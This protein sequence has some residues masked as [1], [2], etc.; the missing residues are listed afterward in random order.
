[1][2][3]RRPILR[4]AAVGVLALPILP[5]IAQEE[6]GLRMRFGLEQRLEYA[7]NLA[8][9]LPAEGATAV[10]STRLSFNLSSETRTER[11]ALNVGAALKL[12]DGPDGRDAGLGDP[13]LE[14]SYAREAANATFGFDA[15]YRSSEVDFL[16]PLED[17]INDDGVIELPEDIDDLTGTGDRADY[18]INTAIEL[19]TAAPLGLALS[20]GLNRLDYSNVSNADLVD[21]RRARVK[22][23]VK[24]R[25][26]EI[27]QGRIGLN[28]ARYEAKDAEETLRE[29]TS[30]EVGLARELSARAV[31][32]TMLG[33]SIV[34][35]E[36]FGITTRTDGLTGRIGLDY[37]MPNGTLTSEITARTNQ[38]GTRLGLSFGRSLDLPAGALSVNIGLTKPEGGDTA[39]IGSLFWLHE[40][41]DGQITA[42]VGRTVSTTNQDTEKLSTLVA[43]GYD[44]E[45]TALS[46]LAVDFIYAVTDGTGTD[47]AVDRGSLT[48]SYRHA[49]TTDWDM[50][51]GLA[52]R[53]REEA[54][55]GRAKSQSVFVSLSRDFDF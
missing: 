26:S 8:L 12:V 16:R 10:S 21:I 43:L 17:F 41:P 19:G 4:L 24:L 45:I 49:L 18:G 42:R 47:P 33:Y 37:A 2:L 22:A 25:F 34:D 52:H 11:L 28:H 7:D 50:N 5:A 30:L 15:H 48:A 54:G 46:G 38:D 32:D 44:H 27:T 14:L 1:M 13:R 40:L 51:F 53:M 55:A 31:L 9:E 3:V 23:T 36:E 39:V 20:A 29:T 35:T 6:G